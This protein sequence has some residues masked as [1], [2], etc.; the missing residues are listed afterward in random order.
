[1]RLVLVESKCANSAIGQ[2]ILKVNVL[3]ILNPLHIKDQLLA[4]PLEPR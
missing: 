4:L 2:G 1:M 3:L